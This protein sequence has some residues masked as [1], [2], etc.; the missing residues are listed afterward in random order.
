MQTLASDL[1]D[2]LIQHLQCSSVALGQLAD[3]GSRFSEQ[4]IGQGVRDIQ[5][6]RAQHAIPLL[7]KAHA[8]ITASELDVSDPGHEV[9]SSRARSLYEQVRPFHITQ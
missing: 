3:V 1:T 7:E 2:Q 5:A 4:L 8:Q 6:N 9:L